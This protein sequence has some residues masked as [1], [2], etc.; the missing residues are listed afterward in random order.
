MLLSW[1]LSTATKGEAGECR[2]WETGQQ[3]L[4]N[5]LPPEKNT[6]RVE[7]RANTETGERRTET[8]KKTQR[9]N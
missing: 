7:R 9:A 3:P 8:E 1:S 4:G 6:Q 5:G 2:G